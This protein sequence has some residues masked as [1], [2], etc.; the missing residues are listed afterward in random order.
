VSNITIYLQSGHSPTSQ[1]CLPLSQLK[2]K[3][4]F[5]SMIPVVAI[6]LRCR[7]RI[8]RIL[9]I[10]AL[11]NTIDRVSSRPEIHAQF[12]GFCSGSRSGFQFG[13][14]RSGTQQHSLEHISSTQKMTFLRKP[15][16]Y[17][18]QSLFGRRESN[19]NGRQ[20][21]HSYLG[22]NKASK[23]QTSAVAEHD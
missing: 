6:R 20:N 15:I 23:V 2:A 8:A 16:P 11:S 5:P 13:I 22:A 7:T 1:T 10:A 14:H 9:A 19:P 18:I 17:L 21:V 12:S 4:I 3:P